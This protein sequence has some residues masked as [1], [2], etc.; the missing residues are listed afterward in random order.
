MSRMSMPSRKEYLI[1]LKPRYLK[2]SK[3]DKGL[4]LDEVSGTT[5]MNRNYLMERLSPETDLDWQTRRPRKR[6]KPIYDNEVIYYLKKVWDILDC[7][8]G[9]RLV[10]SMEDALNALIR[11]GELQISEEMRTKLCT[12]SASTIDRRLSRFRKGRLRRLHGS[13]KPGSLLKKQIPIELSRWNETE[14][15]HSEMDLVSHNGGNPGGYFAHTLVDTDL[16]SGWTEQ[17]AFMGKS[18]KRVTYAMALI[19]GR[20]PFDRKS[21]DT[22]SGGEF[23]NWHLF[24]FC[25]ENDIRFTRG[26]PGKKNDNAHVEQKNWTHVRQLVGYRRYDTKR[27]VDLLNDLYSNEWRLYENFFQATLKLSEKK[28]VG[29]HLHRKYKKPVSPYKRIMGSPEIPEEVKAHLR[30][31]FLSLNPAGLK[32]QIEKKLNV[33]MK[34]AKKS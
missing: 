5:G 26:R 6:R 31:Q 10:G 19:D 28:R 33:I 2:A 1:Q 11:H 20:R 16:S 29:G 17:V 4:L 3:K 23:I 18:E 7:P 32:R 22:D 34:T 14:L 21:I 13:T 15:G 8:C 25:R 30:E 27:Q 9:Q 24:G 12:V